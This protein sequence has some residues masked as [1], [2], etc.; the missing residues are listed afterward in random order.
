MR[1]RKL[2]FQLLMVA[3]FAFVLL[4]L[5]SLHEYGLSDSGT[6]NS[7]QHTAWRLCASLSV[8]IGLL[9]LFLGIGRWHFSLRILLI[10]T[11]LVAVVLGLIVWAAR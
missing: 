6:T 7:D 5:V 1:F 4:V 10:A 11:T 9:A 8:I 2:R 3:T